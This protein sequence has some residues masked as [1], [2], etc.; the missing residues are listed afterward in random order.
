MN[1]KRKLQFFLISLLIIIPINA[2]AYEKYLIPGGENIGISIKTNGAYVVG[3]Y[4][5]D[6]ISIAKKAGLK[7]G[8]LI[9]HINDD[10]ISNTGDLINRIKDSSNDIDVKFTYLRNNKIG[11]VTINLK[12]EVDGSYK[13]GIYV[14]DTITGIGTLTYINPTNNTFGSLG[15]EI[16]DSSTRDI[17]KLSSGNIF[18]ST[19]TSI[20]KSVVGNPGEKNATLNPNIVYGSITKNIETG[21]YGNYTKKIDNINKIE[22]ATM[23][24]VKIGKA[25]IIT[26]LNG[27][28]KETFEIEILSIDKMSNIKNFQIRITDQNLLNKTGG[29]VKGM[30][31]SPIIQNNKII[32]AVTHTMI[33]E[34]TKGYGISIIK[35]LENYE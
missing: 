21:I 12:R 18:S 11:N 35:M 33:D 23:D 26:V 8:D 4:E 34:P 27:N 29:I 7:T 15:H 9:T 5:V 17:F 25:E 19:I 14:K 2:F 6:G 10:K 1:F 22:V 3:F 28:K 24:D 13:T 30:S 20:K 32:G 31:G 16:I